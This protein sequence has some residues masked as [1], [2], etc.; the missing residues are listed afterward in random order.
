M[1]YDS[2]LK[3]LEAKGI[4]PD[5]KSPSRCVFVSVGGNVNWNSRYGEQYGGSLKN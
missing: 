4:L 1:S 2:L 5:L 3:L